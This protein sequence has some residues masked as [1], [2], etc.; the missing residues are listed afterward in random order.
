MR[1]ASGPLA[2]ALPL[3]TRCLREAK[4][5]FLYCSSPA[6]KKLR[7]HRKTGLERGRGEVS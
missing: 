6:I 3:E 5:L 2:S 4:S 7:G 1:G